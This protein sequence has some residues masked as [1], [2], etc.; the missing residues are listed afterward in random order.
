[1]TVPTNI[2]ARAAVRHVYHLSP[3]RLL[4]LPLVWA[5]II[6]LLILAGLDAP[7][8]SSAEARAFT[9]T[10]GIFTLIMLPFFAILWQSR[11]VL[12]PEGITH[13]QFGYSV[14]S[15]WSNL[16]SLI[17]ARGA[18][19]LV[20]REPGTHSGLLKLSAR[21]LPVIVLGSRLFGDPGALAAGRLILLGPFMSRWKRGS[22]HDDLRRWAPQLFDSSGEVRCPYTKATRKGEAT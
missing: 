1:M 9:L 14:R 16:E 8:L 2:A 13:H 6:G 10:A 15:N 22:L 17:L 5:L 3:L 12:T 11:L 19:S 21:L 7:S 18:E 4:P 20:L